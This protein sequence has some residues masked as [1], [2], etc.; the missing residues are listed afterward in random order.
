MNAYFHSYETVEVIYGGKCVIKRWLLVTQHFVTILVL[1][2]PW[3]WRT[4]T[5]NPVCFDFM[6]KLPLCPS[7]WADKFPFAPFPLKLLFFPVYET[8]TNGL[9]LPRINVKQLSLLLMPTGA[10][11]LCF[12]SVG[13]IMESFL[14]YNRSF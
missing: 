8:D 9:C 10:T 3:S 6:K 4:S 14:N 11:E 13:P 12:S 2:I 5:V 7:S 1:P